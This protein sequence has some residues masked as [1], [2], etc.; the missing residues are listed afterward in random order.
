M[1]SPLSFSW[2][3]GLLPSLPPFPPPA[4]LELSHIQDSSLTTS[5]LNVNV[6]QRKDIT[7]RKSAIDYGSWNCCLEMTRCSFPGW[8]KGQSGHFPIASI[9]SSPSSQYG[10]VIQ[11][12]SSCVGSVL[13]DNLKPTSFSPRPHNLGGRKR[14]TFSV[15]FH[16]HFTTTLCQILLQ[17]T[18]SLMV[19]TLTQLLAS[20][21]VSLQ[22][23]CV[24]E[25]FCILFWL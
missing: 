24:L 21:S 23:G 1:C 7:N 10:A 19:W 13:W 9:V 5:Y 12:L 14:G 20:H 11:E 3:D 6:I 15:I 8:L 25:S 17:V 4:L 16:N 18:P 2:T 22:L